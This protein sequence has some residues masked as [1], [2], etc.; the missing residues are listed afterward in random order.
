MR[1]SKIK[2]TQGEIFGEKAKNGDYVVILQLGRPTL[3]YAVS[4]K[5]GSKVETLYFPIKRFE[6]AK[7]YFQKVHTSIFKK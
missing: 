6:N 2:L 4:Y 1:I 7:K 3:N 5:M